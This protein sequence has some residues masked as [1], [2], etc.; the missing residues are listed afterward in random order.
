V[1]Q[2]VGEYDDEHPWVF[3]T[4]PLLAGRKKLTVL[5]PAP[6]FDAD[7]DGVGCESRR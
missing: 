3:C 2:L 7:H 6:R 4:R 5:I 1:A